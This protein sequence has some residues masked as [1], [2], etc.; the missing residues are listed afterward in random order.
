VKQPIIIVEDDND[1][2][3]VLGELL[4]AEGYVVATSAS[5]DQALELFREGP[6]P[7]LV[8]SDLMMPGIS[9]EK[10]HD[11]MKRIGL[12]QVPIIVMSASN[13]SEVPSPPGVRARFC[14]PIDLERLLAT[15]ETLVKTSKAA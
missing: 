1:W 4:V 2:R 9:Y 3:Q 11:V 10:F 6:R 12:G 8:I 7:S 15:V 14:K 5:R 13:E